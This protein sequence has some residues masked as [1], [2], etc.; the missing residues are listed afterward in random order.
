M[1]IVVSVIGD[2]LISLGSFFF[3]NHDIRGYNEHVSIN[4]QIFFSYIFLCLLGFCCLVIPT[5]QVLLRI[6]EYCLVID[7]SSLEIESLPVKI[8]A[9]LWS[10]FSLL[11]LARSICS[12]KET[13]AQE[14]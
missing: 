7:N 14:N 2:L 13:V 11:V 8:L 1:W 5:S 6:E 4:L 10:N 9:L 12:L 3:F